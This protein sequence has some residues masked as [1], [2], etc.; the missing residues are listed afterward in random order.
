MSVRAL[1]SV[2]SKHEV[3]PGNI[4]ITMYCV[5]PRDNDPNTEEIKKFFAASPSGYFQFQCVNPA[6]S[7]Q[8]EIGKLYYVDIT[9]HPS[10]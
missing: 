1:M 4:A 2:G 10:N 3:A 5:Y 7:E 6:A 9:P 8:L